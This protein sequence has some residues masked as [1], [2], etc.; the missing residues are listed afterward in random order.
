MK[1]I[2]LIAG[3]L[4]VSTSLLHSESLQERT[5]GMNI[6]VLSVED[7]SAEAVGCYGNSVVQTPHVDRL[8]SRGIQFNRAYCQ[9]PVCN[10]S[11]ASFGT[12][13]RP[14]STGVYGNGDKMDATIPEGVT[15]YADILQ[16]NP[17]AIIVGSG[18]I[19]HKWE[20]S[21]RFIDG[22]DE[23]YYTHAYDRPDANF[24][25]VH[26]SIMTHEEVME[27]A[28]LVYKFLP[29]EKV[30]ARLHQK[31]EERE[32]R[33][34]AGE[35]NTWPLR[36]PFQ[37]LMAEQVGDSGM[38]AEEMEDGC[39][40]KHAVS[41]IERFAESGQQFCLTL[42]FYA[43]HTPLLA[44]KEFVDLYPPEQME[45]TD[46]P[47][48]KDRNIPAVA[49][50]NGS[51]YDIFNGLY[52]EYGPTEQRQREAISAYYAT[53]SYID[54]LIGEVLT[55]LEENKLAGN[56]IVILLSDHGFHLGE[57]GLWSKFTLFEQSTR[58][59]FIIYV[60]DLKGNG[61]AAEGIVELVDFAPTLYDIWDLESPDNLEGL[62]L[63]PLLENPSQKWKKAAYSMIPI[64]GLGRA[65]RTERYR[66]SEWRSDRSP[67][68]TQDN[69]R[70]VELYDLQE[71]P[72][73]H[74]NLAGLPEHA[75]TE[76][77]L[78]ELLYNGWRAA[79]PEGI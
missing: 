22:F 62:S 8:A 61:T 6:L 14:D 64:G 41:L 69:L 11:R 78:R 73:E 2:Y 3:L 51:N 35:K 1:N 67:D 26:A 21:Y 29:D 27:D 28:E 4:L 32:I 46:A 76:A 66:Y 40:S 72:N 79:L 77:M 17:S 23:I 59:P 20:E 56:T 60:P 24:A 55:A 71:D 15:F 68:F 50:R 70:A 30:V 33:L 16:Q 45:L 49:K 9:G 13:L 12:G 31:R 43:P 57:H 19:V 10:P 48:R 63:L 75:K 38:S 7:W 65:V 25:G 54:S 36:K 5:K 37:Q 52:P 53:A 58:V 39:I 44:P 34:A 47:A 42:G 18:K 74:I